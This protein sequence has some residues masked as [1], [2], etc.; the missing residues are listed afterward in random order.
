MAVAVQVAG[1]DLPR[2]GAHGHAA[3]LAEAPVP[4]AEKNRDLARV[5]VPGREV[6]VSV[7]VEVG[8]LQRPASRSGREVALG[9]E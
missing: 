4:L 9:P 1:G 5:E 8:H 3:V 2:A 7:P 6:G